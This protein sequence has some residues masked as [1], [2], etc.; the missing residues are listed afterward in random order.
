MSLNGPGER[1]SDGVD[2]GTQGIV[3]VV[4][5]L[6]DAATGHGN[7]GPEAANLSLVI[8]QWKI[9]QVRPVFLLS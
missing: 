9:T 2:G 7:L 3:V 4:V 5:L 6:S 1:R 8:K